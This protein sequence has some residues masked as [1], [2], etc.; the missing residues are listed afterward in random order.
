MGT[1]VHFSWSEVL[2][3]TSTQYPTGALFVPRLLGTLNSR[4]HALNPRL[5]V[6]VSPLGTRLCKMHTSQGR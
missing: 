5:G 6:P 4:P 3:V 2:S 1:F